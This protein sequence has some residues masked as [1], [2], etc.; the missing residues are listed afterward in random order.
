MLKGK[1]ESETI[2]NL[3]DELVKSSPEFR[4]GLFDIVISA[5]DFSVAVFWSTLKY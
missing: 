5:S 3:Y 4:Q 2:Q 1:D